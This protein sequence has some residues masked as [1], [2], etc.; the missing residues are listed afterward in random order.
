[1]CIRDRYITTGH[2]RAFFSRIFVEMVMLWLPDIVTSAVLACAKH[3][4]HPLTNQS[5]AA[6]R[7]RS[8]LCSKLAVS[9]SDCS[10]IGSLIGML[11]EDVICSEDSVV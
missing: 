9:Q 6:A 1:M 11:V 8:A 4:L 5:A 10:P 3:P 7:Q 2:T